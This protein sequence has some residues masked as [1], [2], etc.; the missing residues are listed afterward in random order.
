MRWGRGD[1]RTEP[2]ECLTLGVSR[3]PVTEEDRGSVAR[4]TRQPGVQIIKGAKK[5]V[6][7]RD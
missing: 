6:V 1:V 3:G 4:E 5:T 7:I 2:K